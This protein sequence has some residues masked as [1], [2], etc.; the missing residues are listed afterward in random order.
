MTP[1]ERGP[2]AAAS[3]A[4]GAVVTT[5]AGPQLGESAFGSSF[6]SADS[7][8][9]PRPASVGQPK[10]EEASTAE[11]KAEEGSGVAQAPADWRRDA[12]ARFKKMPDL[13]K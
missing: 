2:E 7:F 3:A 10:A 5:P 1:G 6:F 12:L 13:S 11:P 4:P 9:E 8:F